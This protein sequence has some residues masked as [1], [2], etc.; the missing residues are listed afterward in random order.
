MIFI[1][2]L[3]KFSAHT[4]VR[5]IFD[6]LAK[7]RRFFLFLVDFLANRLSVDKIL[8]VSVDI[9]YFDDISAD[10]TDF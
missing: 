5:Y 8:S 9:R 1:D 10:K 3:L 7:Y 6:I 2:I 4:R